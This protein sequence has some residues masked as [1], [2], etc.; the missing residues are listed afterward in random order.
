MHTMQNL[1]LNQPISEAETYSLSSTSLSLSLSSRDK[2]LA[3]TRT[4]RILKTSSPVIIS[5]H[6]LQPLGLHTFCP[7]PPTNC[8]LTAESGQ[9]PKMA[10]SWEHID[11][12]HLSCRGAA[13]P[14]N[15]SNRK[16]HSIWPD[17]A[18]LKFLNE[19]VSALV[20][21][22]KEEKGSPVLKVALWHVENQ[23]C[24]GKLKRPA[25]QWKE[26]REG[27]V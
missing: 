3:L 17:P 1:H 10:A 14:V 20:R 4:K 11:Q 23:R 13:F 16:Q 7:P 21:P 6:S 22:W 12:S 9:S 8:A 26:G 18:E 27:W 25:K 5:L 15:I 19:R 2:V 24:E